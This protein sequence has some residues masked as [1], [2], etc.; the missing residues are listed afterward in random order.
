MNARPYG[1]LLMLPLL[2][3]CASCPDPIV[4]PPKVVTV[5][6]PV[7][8]PCIKDIP[9]KPEECKPKDSTRQEYLRCVL[10][11]SSLNQ[12]YLEKLQAVLLM[13]KGE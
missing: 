11:N 8:V 1:S 9:Q 3:A 7:A 2:V 4:E 13:C 12:A 5:N 10:A 6:I